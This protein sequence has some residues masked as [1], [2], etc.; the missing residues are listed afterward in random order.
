DYDGQIEALTA[1]KED[2]VNAQD[3]EEAAHLLH[4]ANQLKVRR[5][6]A[7]REWWD[8]YTIDPAWLTAHSGTALRVARHINQRRSWQELPI[9]ADA[10]EEAGCTD[11]VLLDHC[12]QPG[13]HGPRCWV[14]DLLICRG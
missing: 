1:R 5:Q 8:A 7:L 13:E 11:R 2:A 14:I 3:F 6:V 10:L 9:L 4:Q 12:R